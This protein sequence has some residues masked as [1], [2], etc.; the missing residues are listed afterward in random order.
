[1]SDS[2]K[3]CSHW[4]I[5]ATNAADRSIESHERILLN[6]KDWDT[7][8][9]ALQNPPKLNEALKRAAKRYCARMSR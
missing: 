5:N 8:Y 4:R 3:E 1:M 2:D 6:Q 7:F 9:D